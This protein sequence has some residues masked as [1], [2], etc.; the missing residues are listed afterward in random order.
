MAKL[1]ITIL[2][3]LFNRQVGIKQDIFKKQKFPDLLA[4]TEQVFKQRCQVN[5]KRNVHWL[6]KDK[7]GKLIW[8]QSQGSSKALHKYINTQNPLLYPT[9]NLD[10]FLQQA[11]CQKVMLI[12]DTSGMG[13]TTVLTHLAKQIKQKYPTCWV[14]RIDLIGHTGVLEDQV[15]Q[16]IQANEF[17]V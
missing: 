14:V 13:K 2:I 5:P 9:E 10:K 11:Q 1:K 7:S 15:K 12:A 3:E 16:K 8:K 6:Q 17:F 4:T